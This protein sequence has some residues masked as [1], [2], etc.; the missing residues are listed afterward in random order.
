MLKPIQVR[1][2][3][4]KAL[5]TSLNAPTHRDER[6]DHSRLSY[7][8]FFLLLRES[9]DLSR[10]QK[11]GGGDKSPTE[12][13]VCWAHWGDFG[14]VASLNQGGYT[15]MDSP[16]KGWPVAESFVCLSIVCPA[17]KFLGLSL[18]FL[19][20]RKKMFLSSVRKRF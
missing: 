9:F 14:T 15:C 3:T 2:I 4:G 13:L 16:G 10:E 8:H 6:V 5:P 18:A 17:F 19:Q 1:T 12:G 20:S 7:N 11:G